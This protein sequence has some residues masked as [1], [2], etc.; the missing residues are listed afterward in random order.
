VACKKGETYQLQWY[1][2]FGINHLIKTVYF[3]ALT[4]KLYVSGTILFPILKVNMWL[5]TSHLFPRGKAVLNIW[6]VP[7]GPIR[8]IVTLLVA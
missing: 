5:T 1:I 3:P 8:G 4:I 7:V 6:A 2:T